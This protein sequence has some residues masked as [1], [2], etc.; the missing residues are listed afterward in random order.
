MIKSLVRSLSRWARRHPEK[1]LSQEPPKDTDVLWGLLAQELFRMPPRPAGERPY[2]RLD[3]ASRSQCG[4]GP[5]LETILPV[6]L[7]QVRSPLLKT[8]LR[9]TLYHQTRIECRQELNSFRR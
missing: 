9:V 8:Q 6:K 4:A 7:Q 5:E 1:L 2:Q 3:H